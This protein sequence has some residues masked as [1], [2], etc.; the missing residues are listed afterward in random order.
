MEDEVR[1][2]TNLRVKLTD[3]EGKTYYWR[4]TRVPR[5]V[6]CNYPHNRV[7]TGWEFESHD[8]CVRFSEG[9]WRELVPMFHLVAEN[10]GLT[11]N[12]S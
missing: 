12:L 6:N 5:I 8:G 3:A 11:T 9:P 4:V 2:M 7:M 1:Y 10:Y